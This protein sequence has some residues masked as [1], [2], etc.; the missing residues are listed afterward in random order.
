MALDAVA[1]LEA[2]GNIMTQLMSL[3]MISQAFRLMV[4]QQASG[5]EAYVARALRYIDPDAYNAIRQSSITRGFKIALIQQAEQAGEGERERLRR[6]AE[7]RSEQPWVAPTVPPSICE[8]LPENLPALAY[9]YV[10]YAITTPFVHNWSMA[11]SGNR[12]MAMTAVAGPCTRIAMA[13]VAGRLLYKWFIETITAE[14]GSSVELEP[15]RVATFVVAAVL[16]NLNVTP[17]LV[18]ACRD[19]VEK[20]SKVEFGL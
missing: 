4:Q 11:L 20:L 12:D 3:T 5:E 10:Q 18:L 17:E 1:A 6:E 7:R 16:R 9:E 19:D 15:T 13:M 8:E 14:C 2:L